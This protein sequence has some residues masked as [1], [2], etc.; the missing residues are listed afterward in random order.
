MQKKEFFSK[1]SNENYI[2][3]QPRARLR[4]KIDYQWNLSLTG[5]YY[6]N[7]SS[8]AQLF[9][10]V[11]LKNYRSLYRNPEKTNVTRSKLG[12]L[13]LGY[14]NILKGFLFSNSTTFSEYNSDFVLASSL[15]S[16]GLI[17]TEAINS[18]NKRV[19][20]RNTTNLN[21]SFFRI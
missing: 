17:Q 3:F 9:N 21:K 14:S 20:F 13:N 11:I 16:N 7:V 15:D 8:F 6:A 19:N 1:I 5:N 2:F 18:P 10:G 4:Y 12:I